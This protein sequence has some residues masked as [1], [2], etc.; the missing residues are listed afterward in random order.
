MK[1]ISRRRAVG[2]EG[3]DALRC[4]N[5]VI[6]GVACGVFYHVELKTA[7]KRDFF[8]NV[9]RNVKTDECWIDKMINVN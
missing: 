3:P 2:V 8:N 9:D 7:H 5:L 4:D 1:G 6:C